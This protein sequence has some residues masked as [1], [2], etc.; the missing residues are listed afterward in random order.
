MHDVGGIDPAIDPVGEQCNRLVGVFLS[1]RAVERAVG[2]ER[3]FGV[4]EK[5]RA[6]DFG[7][8]LTVI[9]AGVP[10]AVVERGAEAVFISIGIEILP[11]CRH[12]SR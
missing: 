5:R 6:A 9:E 8:R 11:V 4:Q 10:R 3:E 1:H 12:S 2:Q 7:E